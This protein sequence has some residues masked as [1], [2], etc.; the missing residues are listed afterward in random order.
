MKQ[1]R[2]TYRQEFNG[3][4]LQDS[5]IK[6]VRSEREIQQ[7]ISALYSDPHVFSVD[8]ELVEQS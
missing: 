1:Y 2:I 4:I 6:Y 8:Y 7:A 3:K 5:Y